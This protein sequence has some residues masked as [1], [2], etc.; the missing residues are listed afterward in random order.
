MLTIGKL[1]ALADVRTDTLRYYEREQLLTP[2]SKRQ[3]GYRVYDKDAVRRIRFIKQAQQC[4]F[5][6]SEIRQLLTLRVQASAC[7]GD[8]RK[9][10]VEKKQQLECKIR[11]MRA[12]SK[13][14]DR[15]I[16]ECAGDAHPIDDCSILSALD[17]GVGSQ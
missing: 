5:T 16:S 4:G 15:L 7:C 13:A 1:A 10:A 17:R 6:L 2:V 12:M 3:S 9:L 14:L 11:T 8:V